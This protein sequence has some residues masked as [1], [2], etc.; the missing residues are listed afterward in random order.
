MGIGSLGRG[1]VNPMKGEKTVVYVANTYSKRVLLAMLNEGIVLP[2]ELI[3]IYRAQ[4][5]VDSLHFEKYQ[6]PI[7]QYFEF[8]NII[9]ILK[10]LND[11]KKIIS[12]ITKHKTYDLYIP[13]QDCLMFYK[14]ANSKKCIKFN[15]IEEGTASLL[16]ITNNVRQKSNKFL[17]FR[18]F[19]I[20]NRYRFFDVHN[21]K[22]K[23][24]VGFFQPNEIFNDKFI[25]LKPQIKFTEYKTEGAIVFLDKT[26]MGYK[27]STEQ[28]LKKVISLLKEDKIFFKLHPSYKE[29]QISEFKNIIV[30]LEK[31]FRKKFNLIQTELTL[32]EIL[33]RYKFNSFYTGY[34]STII[35]LLCIPQKQ[36]NLILSSQELSK[37]YG[38][39]WREFN[40]K[41]MEF[42]NRNSLSADLL[43]VIIY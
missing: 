33:N 14:L 3:I 24:H 35:E 25:K 34:S 31:D 27:T 10:I 7:Y 6:V 41:I 5:L 29:I 20:Q 42:A 22:F 19:G 39:N 8:S 1:G 30:R 37:Y 11:C 21:E 15:Y 43:K 36:V 16:I 9:K 38:D 12:Q 28:E 40:Q 18:I 13:H 17:L 23:S 32:D 2:S 26:I 4:S